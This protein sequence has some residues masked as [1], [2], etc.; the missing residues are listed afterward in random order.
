MSR[1]DSKGCLLFLMKTGRLPFEAEWHDKDGADDDDASAHVNTDSFAP[2]V[3]LHFLDIQPASSM[4][5]VIHCEFAGRSTAGA[6]R[7][8]LECG[9]QGSR[10]SSADRFAR[11]FVGEKA[12]GPPRLVRA[13]PRMCGSAGDC[14]LINQHVVA[15]TRRTE[16]LDHPFWTQTACPARTLPPQPVWQDMV[17]QLEER[18]LLKPLWL[19]SDASLACL[20]EVNTPGPSTTAEEKSALLQRTPTSLELLQPTAPVAQE[21]PAKSDTFD[22]H[23][24]HDRTNG[25]KSAS[26]RSDVTQLLLTE[27]VEEPP[28]AMMQLLLHPSDLQI[29]PI[30]GNK[31]IEVIEPMRVNA[32]TLPFTPV[33]AKHICNFEQPRIEEH[34]TT[35]Y[36]A[37]LNQ[38]NKA[39]DRNIIAYLCAIV[40]SPEVA[41]VVINSRLMTALLRAVK[42]SR[43]PSTKVAITTLVA[44]CIRHATY[45]HPDG[46]GKDEDLVPSL[47]ALLQD[48]DGTT[49]RR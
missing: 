30:M 32:Q 36:R 43:T 39:I 21:T 29:K 45:I 6:K 35:V 42:R 15:L 2:T 1:V 4:C 34:L 7:R 48:P 28:D 26:K 33:A 23:I 49:R 14:A 10:E 41:N 12:D 18:Q 17:N 24:T 31:T 9:Q 3:R 27:R 19:P 47:N 8:P 22:S 16:L 38:H 40:A 25:T 37:M 46:N 13:L 11:F 44:G 5:D 20:H